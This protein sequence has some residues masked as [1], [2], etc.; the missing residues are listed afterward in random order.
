MRLA[1][2][3]ITQ[4][5]E[6]IKIHFR[7]LEYTLYLYGSR[8]DDNLRGGDIDLLIVTSAE[9]V[10]L[11]NQIELEL[12]VSIK[13]KSHIGDRRNDLKAVTQDDLEKKPFLKLNSQS[14]IKI[15]A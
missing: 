9:G 10:S 11:F 1:Q 2:E 4:I 7:N 12:L 3:Q 5:H 8:T 15:S 6:S 14:M 13:G